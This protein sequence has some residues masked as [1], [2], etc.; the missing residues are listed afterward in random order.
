VDDRQMRAGGWGID[1]N[2]G[3][4]DKT[5]G[6]IGLGK[7]GSQVARVGLAFSMNVI[8]WTPNLTRE[9]CAEVG[10]G[11]ASQQVLLRDADFVT[12]HLVLG[13]R[14][15]GL[16][17]A[18]ELALMKPTAF[19]INTS[20]GPIVDERALIAALQSNAIAGA[21]LDV[22]ETEPLPQSHPFRALSNAVLS[23]HQGY[24]T[25]ENYRIFYATAIENILGWLDGKPL[26]LL[27]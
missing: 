6:V 19:L 14:S 21:G 5:L 26:N 11:Y 8:A 3:L 2:V 22:F 16:I 18:N 27:S 25:H 9:R 24:V 4:K 7:L 17:G 23:P 20:R 1:L 10:V 12:I 13:E 15:R